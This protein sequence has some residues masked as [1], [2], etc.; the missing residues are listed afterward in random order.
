MAI[1]IFLLHF[2]GV[3]MDCPRVSVPLDRISRNLVRLTTLAGIALI[4]IGGLPAKAQNQEACTQLEAK[5]DVIKAAD[6]EIAEADGIIDAA[7]KSETEKTAAK[8][9]KEAASKIKAAASKSNPLQYELNRLSTL[10]AELRVESSSNSL[11]GGGQAW[12]NIVGAPFS[13]E[14]ANVCVRLYQRTSPQPRSA[15]P[16]PP[17]QQKPPAQQT[18]PTQSENFTQVSIA[19][20]YRF[21]DA[22]D[23]NTPKYRIIFNVEAPASPQ[24]QSTDRDYLLVAFFAAAKPADSKLLTYFTTK[25]VTHKMPAVIAA[26]LF[27]SII[28]IGLAWATYDLKDMGDLTGL[29]RD[30]YAV[31]PIRITAGVLGDSSISQVQV[32]LFTFIV[33]GLLFYLWLRTGL[34]ASIS[35]DL[36]YL[37]GISAVG[38]GG[39]KYTATLKAELDKEANDFAL[40]KGWYNWTPIPAAKNAN[41]ANLLMTGQRLDVYKFQVA[42]F[43][44]VVAAYV[45]SSGQNDLGDVTISET[46]LYLIGISQG[47]YI[48]G[49][50]ITDRKTLIEN[51]IKKMNALEKETDPAKKKEYAAAEETAKREFASFFQLEQDKPRDLPPPAPPAPIP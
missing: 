3:S 36:L 28:Y 7:G 42:V 45:L 51:A 49:K 29:S 32:V 5:L 43:T 25:S 20:S 14:R 27:V 24:L 17:A 8:E 33:A 47:V 38:A 34:L 46:M 30:L 15:A 37:L 41:L 11:P 35:A 12:F 4:A 18:E 19:Q 6:R 13:D 26:L 16:P 44:L 40:A 31:S 21:V 23:K 1:V 39:A 9:Q 50:A 10:P 48:G 22:T 2:L